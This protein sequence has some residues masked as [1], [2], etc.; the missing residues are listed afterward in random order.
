MYP[1]KE[2]CVIHFKLSVDFRGCDYLEEITVQPMMLWL[3]SESQ[4]AHLKN[5]AKFNFVFKCENKVCHH[6]RFIFFPSNDNATIPIWNPY[7]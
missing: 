6:M 2:K 7:Y 4:Y 5:N 3:I 1:I